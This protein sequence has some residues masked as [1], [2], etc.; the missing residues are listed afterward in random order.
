MENSMNC[1]I[2][3]HYHIPVYVEDNSIYTNGF[4]G[5]FLDS[6]ANYSKH[7]SYF[8]YLTNK[9]DELK[10]DYEIKSKNI[11]IV[12][13]GKYSKNTFL[14]VFYSYLKKNYIKREIKN[15][16]Y[17]IIRAPTGLSSLFY[18]VDAKKAVML[19]GDIG[20]LSQLNTL[21]LLSN[22]YNRILYI[23]MKHQGLGKQHI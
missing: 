21:S 6:L 2:G 10:L 17:L 9:K 13:V 20:D 16:D 8:C 7:V 14:R 22:I 3:I 11:S 15:I 5:V 4:F 12:N 19:I 18:G 23:W 1:K